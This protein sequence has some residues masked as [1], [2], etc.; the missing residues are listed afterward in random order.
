MK[1]R[2]RR[3]IVLLADLQVHSIR[4]VCQGIAEYVSQ[5]RNLD[6]NPWP[7]VSEGTVI[8]PKVDLAHIDGLILS[9]RYR[10]HVCTSRRPLKIPRVGFLDNPTDPRARSVEVDELAI[11]RLAAR[12]LLERGYRKLAF[13]GSSTMRWS[14]FRNEG[15]IRAAHEAGVPCQS[16]TFGLDELPVY[17]AWNLEKRRTCFQQ[18]L[19]RLPKPCGVLAGNDVIACFLIETARHDGINVPKE[20]GVI[21]VDDD[22][23][24][25]AAAHLAIS[26]IQVPFRE[27][28]RQAVAMLHNILEGKCAEKRVV[29]QPTRVIVRT[30][31]DIF[32]TEDRLVNRAQAYIEVNRAGRLKV[33]DVVRAAG[34]TRVTLGKR[35]RKHLDTGIHD[36]ILLQRM[37]HARE[38]LRVGDLNVNEVAL[39]CGFNNTPFF[40]SVFKRA[41]HTTPGQIRR[42]AFARSSK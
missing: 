21:G 27:V 38:L 5:Q 11:G 29:L 25:N 42:D 8:P 4:E 18:V 2:T 12:H 22:P 6:F 16:Y 37:E 32:M 34:T 20:T 10:S 9:E 33:N 24:P 1:S 14:R 39:A 23:I 36:Y 28:G 13:V 35:F 17:W 31:T 30:S 3:Q 40:C 19:S 15:F 41:T 26:S 7:V